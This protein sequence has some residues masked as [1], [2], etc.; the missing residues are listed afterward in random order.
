[1]APKMSK[2]AAGLL[3]NEKAAELVR[4][5]GKGQ[6][7][8]LL[9]DCGTGHLNR[10][11]SVKY[12]HS[13]LRAILEVE[14]FSDFRYKFATAT[15]PSDSDPYAST[16]RMQQEV[17]DSAGMLAKVDNRIKKGF[18]TKNHLLLGLITLRDGGIRKD[19]DKD[20]FWTVPPKDGTDRNKELHE[21]LERGMKVLLLC[22]T[23][24]EYES[25][26]DIML[27]IEVDNQDQTTCMPDHEV[28]LFTRIGL[29]AEQYLSAIEPSE[30]D[31]QKKTLFQTIYKDLKTL[32][33]GFGKK[34][35]IYIYNLAMKLPGTYGKF[36]IKF[37]FHY[38]NPTAL[39]V[40]PE[41]YGYVAKLDDKVPWVKVA[42]L[43]H[44]YMCH[45]DDYEEIGL[46]QYANG[47]TKAKLERIEP[48]H[49]FLT[50]AN[51]FLKHCMAGCQPQHGST[52]VFKAMVRFAIA[53]G[54]LVYKGGGNEASSDQQLGERTNKFAAAEAE[55]WAE[56]R[57]YGV[58]CEPFLAET[59]NLGSVLR[60]KKEGCQPE[61][62]AVVGPPLKFSDT[63][64]LQEDLEYKAAK[65]GIQVGAVV[66]VQK[67]CP[68]SSF[69]RE[70]IKGETGTV[71]SVETTHVNVCF[72]K[73]DVCPLPRSALQLKPEDTA[74][75]SSKK[76]QRVDNP[77]PPKAAP[78]RG[79]IKW[80]H[81]ELADHNANLLS[82]LIVA[83]LHLSETHGPTDDEVGF[84]SPTS[85]PIA[86]RDFKSK[87]MTLFPYTPACS[88]A[89]PE[90]GI[91]IQ[92]EATVGNSPPQ[93]LYLLAPERVAN[94][95]AKGVNTVSPFWNAARAEEP[96]N[97][98]CIDLDCKRQ[99]FAASLQ[100]TAKVQSRQGSAKVLLEGSDQFKAGKGCPKVH[101]ML[102]YFTNIIAVQR[103]QTLRASASNPIQSADNI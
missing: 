30:V 72:S 89:A 52:A 42:L 23:I 78:I 18:L 54:R 36:V 7:R 68:K 87:E 56:V 59:K 65:D 39:K 51:D 4:I 62:K 20:A 74:A 92:I 50:D 28:H 93:K 81:T 102:P 9:D 85:C 96:R 97:A 71:A 73:D 84:L 45:P 43:L 75:E 37:H 76:K 10:A 44:C 2:L 103:G 46:I 22:K 34:D 35:C 12:V 70:V 99:T 38:V 60:D 83:L 63:G 58:E 24:W 31:N 6:S 40:K 66:V 11:I 77:E 95:R 25:L 101:F 53:S 91:Y 16:R 41:I 14:G 49:K 64:E 15:E 48:Q 61:A 90:S 94:P 47:L 26:E 21:V 13:R 79:L 1:M 100:V 29:K 27:I 3:P 88:A 8:M 67:K 5:Y 69:R 80:A 33:G 82:T 86:L 32:S 98:E 17:A 57:K 19:H 55:L